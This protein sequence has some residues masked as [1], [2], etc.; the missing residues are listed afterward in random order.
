VD[1]CIRRQ[2]PTFSFKITHGQRSSRLLSECNSISSWMKFRLQGCSDFL[3]D[4]KTLIVSFPVHVGEEIDHSRLF[5][6][7]E[8]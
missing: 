1:E 4:E 7:I 8:S 5:F 3:V 6:Q 2:P